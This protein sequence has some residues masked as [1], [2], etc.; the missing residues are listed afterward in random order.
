MENFTIYSSPR[1]IYSS[2]LKDIKNA[3]KSIYLETYQFDNDIV[4]KKFRKVL[5]KKVREGVK[6]RILIDVWQST[7]D[8]EFF[9]SLINAGAKVKFFREIKYVLRFISK[10]HER[11]HRKLL[12]IDKNISYIGSANIT[13][14]GL[15]WRELV[16][17]FEGEISIKLF[18]T[19]VQTWNDHGKISKKRLNRIIHKSFKIINDMP[20]QIFTPTQNEY[21][22]LIKHA[23]SEILIITPYFV[24][25][26][27]I[28]SS[29]LEAIKRGVNIIII[30]PFE[31]TPYEL[32]S[33]LVNYVRSGFMG[34]LVERGVNIYTYMPT[35]I[36]TKLLIVDK[37][38][39][40]FG[41]SN[42]D[43]RS[44]MHLHEINLVGRDKEMI[45][46]LRKYFSE[47]LKDCKYFNHNKWKNRSSIR[48]IAEMIV[49]FARR[50]L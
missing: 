45:N 1:K 12:I 29:F 36:H 30:T 15:D 2:M 31:I 43:Y 49:Y 22:N 17:R 44:F 50:Y 9:K 25:S 34:K 47:T 6:V 32:S 10:N 37:K 20:S 23:K 24:P 40:L 33:T 39:F 8:K 7:A 35:M 13:V 4:G 41:S 48:K 11:N 3:K 26:F 16:V 19:F 18:K 14:M 38:F 27:E 46:Q 28:R 21:L 42:L 5:L